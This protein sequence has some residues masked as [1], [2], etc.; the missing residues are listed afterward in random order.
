MDL[1]CE[2]LA[3]KSPHGL[4]HLTRPT[5]RMAHEPGL[6]SP[7]IPTE[8]GMKRRPFWLTGLGENGMNPVHSVGERTAVDPHSGTNRVPANAT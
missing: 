2:L 3:G 5:R 7:R 1:L 8:P 6:R 4:L